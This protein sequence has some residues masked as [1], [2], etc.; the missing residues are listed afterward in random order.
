MWGW[1][2]LLIIIY[3]G[4]SE[5]V[6]IYPDWWQN[7][8]CHTSES[9]SMASWRRH[10]H[11]WRHTM[12]YNHRYMQRWWTYS[13]KKNYNLYKWQ[14]SD[15]LKSNVHNPPCICSR[16]PK[17]TKKTSFCSLWPISW[18]SWRKNNWIQLYPPHPKPQSNNVLLVN[19]EGPGW[20]TIYN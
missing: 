13:Q 12:I 15:C 5:V 14:R 10:W 2:P 9:L 1:F 6:I 18:I 3:G 8:K 19:I 17:K 20:S 16:K 11:W 4:R 7:I